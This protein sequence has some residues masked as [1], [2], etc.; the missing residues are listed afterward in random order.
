[1][2]SVFPNISRILGDIARICL[3]DR[4]YRDSF[5]CNI[6]EAVRSDVDDWLIDFIK[7]HVFSSKDFYEKKRWWE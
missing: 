6:I 5:T 4:L 1:M 2:L 3:L 7:T